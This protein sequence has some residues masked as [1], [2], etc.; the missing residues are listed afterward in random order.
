MRL[1]GIAVTC[2]CW[3]N[4]L[5]WLKD[6]TGPMTETSRCTLRNT[7]PDSKL[8]AWMRAAVLPEV[9]EGVPANKSP[10]SGPGSHPGTPENGLSAWMV[11]L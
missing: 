5:S 7:V 4:Q 8:T 9:N 10:G 2:F 3:G 1:S 11:E 6:S